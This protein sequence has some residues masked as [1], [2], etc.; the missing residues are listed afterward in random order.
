MVRTTAPL[1]EV[2]KHYGDLQNF[3]GG[4][5]R[6][7]RRGRRADGVLPLRRD[8]GVLFGVLHPQG[9]DAIRFFTETKVVITRWL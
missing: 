7:Q 4:E 2:R 1:P 3:T 6:D 8:A 9:R 5:R